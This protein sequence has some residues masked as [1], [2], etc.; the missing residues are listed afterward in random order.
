M[1][2]GT[3]IQEEGEARGI[4]AGEGGRPGMVKEDSRRRCLTH[5]PA[6]GESKEEKRQ[7]QVAIRKGKDSSRGREHVGAHSV[8]CDLSGGRCGW[9][10]GGIGKH[11]K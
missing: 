7:R 9:D 2:I 8:P 5:H 6:N 10:W 11:R 1:A 4:I 3:V